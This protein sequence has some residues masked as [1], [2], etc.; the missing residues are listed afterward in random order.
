MFSALTARFRR[1]VSS[2]LG[3]VMARIAIGVLFIFAAGFGLAAL[4]LALID[5]FGSQTAYWILAG[6]F[7]VLGGLAVAIVSAKEEDES[8]EA[9]QADAGTTAA[10]ADAVFSPQNALTVASTLAPMLLHSS[11]ASTALGAARLVLRNMP[12][13]IL[14]LLITVLTWPF[15]K[16]RTASGGGPSGPRT[17]V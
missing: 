10:V 13:L 17:P 8:A 15:D 5:R 9:A 11:H 6:G 7:A 3:S 16:M 12:L 4:T 2:T 1:S 14:A